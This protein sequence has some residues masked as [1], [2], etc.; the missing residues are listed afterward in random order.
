MLGNSSVEATRI[1][2]ASTGAEYVR[3]MDRMGLAFWQGISQN[4]KL[5]YIQRRQSFL[6]KKIT[7]YNALV[8]ER[9]KKIR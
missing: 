8:G 7:G 1:Y 3:R 4:K 9:H 5:E 2:L 6:G